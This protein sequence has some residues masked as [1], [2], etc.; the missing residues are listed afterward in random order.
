MTIDFLAIAPEIA[1]T[2]TALVVLA[3]DLSLR[4]SAKRFVNPLSAIGTLVAIGFTLALW[5]EE[6]TTFAGTFVIDSFALTFKLLFLVSLLAILGVS[7]RFFAEGR[8]FQGEYYF[9]LLT[10]FIG[11]LLMPSSRDLLLLFVALETVSIPAFVMVGLRK[12][13]LYSSE[14]ALKFFLIGVLS[15]AFMLLGMSFVYGFTGVTGLDAV[16]AAIGMLVA[17]NS[18]DPLLLAAVML[19]IVGFAFKISAVPFHFWAPDTYAGAPMPVTAMLAVSSKAAGFAGLAI[20]SF[21]A[22]QPLAAVW[23]P[24]LGVVAITTMTVGNLGALQQR[25]LIRLLAFSSVAQAGYILLPFG[26]ARAGTDA[27]SVA[28]NQGAFRAVLLYLIAYAVMNIGAFAVAIGVSRRT[29]LRSI[30]DYA[31]LGARSPLLA[32]GMS[33]FMLSLGGAPL[34]V[35]L[36]A[37]FAILEA[38]TIDVTAFSIVL[39]A[40]LVVNSVIAFFYYLKVVRLM[41]LSA[42]AE[43]A[44][45]LDPGFGLKLVTATLAGLTL[46]LGVLPGLVTDATSIA[47]LAAV[48]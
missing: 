11:M 3:A 16:G 27:V 8:Y 32:V 5:G 24:V 21:I 19:V 47:T 1:L 17:A 38:L 25:D 15:V 35:G 44:P 18:V 43:D 14:A 9:L 45:A 20:V 48:R 2:V 10:A 33:L 41:W 28:V 22:F 4:G 46:L 34:T 36:W 31:G 40:A 42:P 30:E 6:R 7:Y 29:G 39:A 12:R 13:D 26:V 23:A 37:K